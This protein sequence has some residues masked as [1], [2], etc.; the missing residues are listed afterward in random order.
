MV[1]EKRRIS[2]EKK[3]KKAMA[4][5]SMGLEDGERIQFLLYINS[6]ESFIYKTVLYN[7]QASLVYAKHL[8]VPF[9]PHL[10]LGR[11]WL[12]GTDILSFMFHSYSA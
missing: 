6:H 12:G 3:F 8:S 5:T 10:L 2:C 9:K 11:C 7:L 1:G 4:L